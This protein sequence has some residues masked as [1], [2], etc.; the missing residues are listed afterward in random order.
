MTLLDEMFV[1]V[2]ETGR[3]S[4]LRLNGV[5]PIFAVHF[6]GQPITPGVC[7]VKLIGELMERKTGR[8]LELEKIVNLKFVH[9]LM[10]EDTHLLT[11]DFA[12]VSQESE[13]GTVHAKGT[14]AADG[15]V[16]TKFSMIWHT[17]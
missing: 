6:P 16:A 3:Q 13:A 10:P 14:I 17:L 1:L 2:S 7:L 12:T 5:H 11:V 15:Q 9:P 8:R 4:V